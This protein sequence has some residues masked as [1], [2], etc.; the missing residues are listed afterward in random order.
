MRLPGW[1]LLLLG[2]LTGIASRPALADPPR[3]IGP[4]TQEKPHAIAG[5]FDLPSGW[6]ITPAGE[7]V[8]KTGDW[9]LKL[10]AAPDGRAIIA[11][12]SGYQP[13]GLTVIDPKTRKTVQEITLRSSWLGMAF[14]PDG[15]T[16]YVSGGNA[17]GDKAP[18]ARA[19]IYAF[20]Y[21]DGRLSDQPIA[22]FDET[23]PLSLIWWSGVAR[24]PTKP[25]LYAANRGVGPAP[26]YVAVFDTNTHALLTRIPVEVSP[27]ELVLSKDGSRLFVSNWSS[28]SVS[29]IDT[30]TNRVI[31][32]IRVGANPN[33]MALSAD[34]RLFVACSNDNTVYV[35]DA[36]RLA[37]I[38]RLST[39]FSS[40][41]PEGST[42]DALS[43]DEA[44]R[45]L[46][47]ANADNNDVA[48]ISLKDPAHSDVL[49]FIPTGWY[50][51]ALTLADQGASLYVGDAKG[52]AAYPD[53]HGPESP[54][55]ATWDGDESIKTLQTTEVE[56]L[57]LAA[58]LT[59]LP[60][61]TKAVLANSPY[62]DALLQHARPAAAATIV[63]SDV[64][65]GSPIQHVIYIIKENRTYDQVLGDLPKTNG[66][67]RL[68]IFGRQVT[69]NHH[70]LAEQFVALDNFY[71]DGEVSVDGHS[72]SNAAYATDFNEKWWPPTYG[73][74][75]GSLPAPAYIPAAGHLWD[76]A[77]RK[78]LTYRS[79]G[80]Y[81]TRAS[82]GKAMEAQP[83]IDALWGHVAKDYL[84]SN[85]R[86]TDNVQVFLKEF[87]A[88][89][90]NFDS[91]DPDKR[92]PGYVVM[93]MPEDHTRGTAPGAFTPV[94]MVAS[95][96]YA[97]GQLVDR[98]T[99]SKYWPTTAI[100]ILEDDA[101]DGP[102][103]VDARRTVALIASP[104]IHRGLVDSTL[105]TT[106]SFVRTIELLLGLP[107]MSQF[108]AAATPLYAAFGDKP[109]LTPY[110]AIAPMVDLNAK[111]T[112]TSYG[113]AASSRMDFSD[114]DRA[115]MHQLNE[116]IWKSVKGAESPMP[117]PVH[118]YRP[119][120]DADR[121][122][123]AD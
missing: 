38:E 56:R 24:H 3:T 49:G 107:P 15:H 97:L 106:S 90:A 7:P 103:H 69:P 9:V 84:G 37:V 113:A 68:T 92:L 28:N 11:G 72:W 117:A 101:Q 114:N 14:S 58:L 104:Y 1:T 100:F 102:D 57:G 66:D 55:A 6:R 60:D 64:G 44:R 95:N 32:T 70:A 59:K 94:A 25:L 105:Y 26:T 112:V 63:P 48:V 41:A 109:D 86:D 96:D 83:G 16:L 122:P 2:L 76:L 39:T 21:Q 31:A 120:A 87:D 123:G 17:N 29:V 82:D 34:G 19:P 110:T 30:A 85:A 116:I 13:H 40:Q 73:G 53:I 61:L 108:D 88:F 45:L 99:H 22:Q 4:P 46:Y 89:E 5:G 50:P 23:I 43:I 118:R 65:V 33:D 75:S 91:P 79:Y 111:N 27:Y 62:N 54:L 36:R 8:A 98:V 71:A 81:A 12:H 18:P 51:S 74:W 121:Q 115:P 52:E 67:P 42:P 77:R 10:I 35:I 119:L 80:E 20:A 93:S 78:G 47:V